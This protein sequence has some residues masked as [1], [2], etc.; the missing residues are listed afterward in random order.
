MRGTAE[1]SAFHRGRGVRPF[2]G[3][4]FDKKAGDLHWTFLTTDEKVMTKN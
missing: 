1:Q 4:Y 3:I 2:P